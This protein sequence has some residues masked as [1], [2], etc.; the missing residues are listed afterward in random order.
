VLG[1]RLGLTLSITQ[2]YSLPPFQIISRFKFS[3]YI[4]FTIHLNITDPFT[5]APTIRLQLLLA[6]TAAAA[7]CSWGPAAAA[8]AATTAAAEQNLVNVWCVSPWNR[9]MNGRANSAFSRS[10]DEEE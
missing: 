2:L 1:G 8:A 3:T 7:V 5:A 9:S 10:R 6:H 4:N